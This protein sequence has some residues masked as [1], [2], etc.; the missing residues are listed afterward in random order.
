MTTTGTR[1]LSVAM[2]LLVLAA[3]S[4]ST[5]NPRPSPPQGQPTATTQG[6]PPAKAMKFRKDARTTV[7][8]LTDLPGIGALKV[9]PNTRSGFDND[10]I[11][12][13]STRI[14][15]EPRYADVTIAE[16]EPALLDEPLLVDAVFA[17]FSITDE[18]KLRMDFAGPYLINKQGV[19]VRAKE[20]RI[21]TIA[22]LDTVTLCAPQG[23]TSLK[24]LQT[25]KLKVT[26]E[27]SVEQC[28]LDLKGESV[29]AVSTDQL[30]L[31][32]R[33][34]KDPS[35]RVLPKLTFGHYENYGIG[36]PKNSGA[37]C[38]L[39]TEH[40]KIFIK[41]G[42][43]EKFFVQNFPELQADADEYKPKITALERCGA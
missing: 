42:D 12:W 20:D 13:L 37:D 22:D 8:V 41:G 11:A 40:I 33:A 2:A 27:E 31:Y 34:A 32:G 4:C 14:G 3:A 43:W 18:R 35:L 38:R 16:R 1:S 29:D 10:L 25:R 30:L 17:A 39:L 28:I 9:G 36:L 6:Q 26:E 19:M 21:A 23:S 24:E 7:G 15:F 5:P